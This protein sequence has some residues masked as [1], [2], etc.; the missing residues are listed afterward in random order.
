ML[1]K[2]STKR[3]NIASGQKTFNSVLTQWTITR[4]NN[5]DKKLRNYSSKDK[6]E[7]I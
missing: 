3:Q 2:K 7:Y 1:R 6:L 5:T 4:N